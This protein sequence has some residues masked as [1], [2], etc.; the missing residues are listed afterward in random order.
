MQIEDK[1][2]T[3]F[4]GE[5]FGITGAEA[6]NEGLKL[7]LIENNMADKMLYMVTCFIW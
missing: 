7:H 4:W 6:Q 5:L 1:P 3:K 2:R